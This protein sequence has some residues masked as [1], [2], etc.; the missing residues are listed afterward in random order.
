MVANPIDRYSIGDRTAGLRYNDD[1]SLTVYVQH[2]SPGHDR[3]P[4]WLP[5]PPGRFYLNART[6]MPRP[7]LLNGSYR[8]P[9][10]TGTR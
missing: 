9:A 8:L 2:E 3:E 4:N 5:A 6:Y 1:G 7:E 10:I